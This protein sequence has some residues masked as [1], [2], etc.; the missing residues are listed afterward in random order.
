MDIDDCA[1][2]NST[3]N[4]LVVGSILTASTN[5]SLILRNLAIKILACRE[6]QP[7]RIIVH[8]FSDRLWLETLWAH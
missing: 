3:L 6:P 8:D 1:V 2:Q 5:S 7:I 4:R